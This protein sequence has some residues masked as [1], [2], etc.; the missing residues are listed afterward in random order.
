M[1][2]PPINYSRKFSHKDWIDFVDSVQAGGTN[3]INGRLHAIEA[4]FD[5]LSQ[6]VAL[7]NAALQAQGAKPPSQTVTAALVPAFAPSG[8]V[9][10]FWVLND[11]AWASKSTTLGGA[12]GILALDP[13]NGVTITQIRVVGKNIVTTNV[14]AFDVTQAAASALAVVD[15]NQYS[16]YIAADLSGSQA[17]DTV[18]IQVLQITYQTP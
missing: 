16:Y 5:V 7:I 3:G 6:V 4:E 12:N 10:A 1:S 14:S 15:R 13:P 2:V 11:K 17:S 9:N 8:T 18:Q